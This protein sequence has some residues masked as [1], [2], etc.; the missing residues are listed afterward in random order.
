MTII[1]ADSLAHVE[2][3][4]TGLFLDKLTGIGGI[5]RGFITEIF[6]DEG[7]GKSTV[8]LQ[9]VAAAQ[10]QGLKCLWADVEWSYS[11]LYAT[12]LGVDNSKLGIIQT[13][14]AE[15]VL[16]AI[17][18]AANSGEWDLIVLDSVGGVLPRKEAE[19]GSDGKTI[20]GQAGLMA[21]FCRKIVPILKQKNVAL[22][23]INHQFVDIMSGRIM[24]SG[25]KK[26]AYHKAISI[27]LKTKTGV[28]IKQG[29]KKVGKIILADVW[30]KNKVGST[31]GMAMEAQIIFGTGFSAAADLLGDAI[32][33]GVITKKG[34]TYYLGKEKLGIGL[35]KT[36]TM[37]EE[38]PVLTDKVKY[39]L[40]GA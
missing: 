18:E 20:G 5:P 26:L 10:K 31:E 17:E 3:I 22:I 33:K 37:L 9:A 11:P 25:G 14:F 36:R 27:R 38:N 8:C 12:F 19:K 28:S 34:N 15:D 32:D 16:D 6:G 39:A 30:G 1:Y 24:Q 40:Q 7:V 4:P 2:A 21:R 35:G 13:A 29:D 23:A